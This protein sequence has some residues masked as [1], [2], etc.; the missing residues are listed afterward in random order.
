MARDRSWFIHK[1]VGAAAFQPRVF[2]AAPA[3]NRRMS[4]PKPYRRSWIEQIAC[5]S[6]ERAFAF[7]RER[8]AQDE[9]LRRQMAQQLSEAHR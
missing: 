3:G 4:N 5:E 8:E 6:Q 1:N 7:M 9:R 2:T